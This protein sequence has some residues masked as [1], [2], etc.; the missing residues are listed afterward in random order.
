MASTTT[1]H[2]QCEDCGKCREVLDEEFCYVC[3]YRSCERGE[4]CKDAA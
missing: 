3:E 4:D 2:T 1:E